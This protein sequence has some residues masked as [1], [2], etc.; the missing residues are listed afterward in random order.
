MVFDDIIIGSGLSALGTALGLEPGRRILVLA[1]PTHGAFSYY[2]ARR[3]VPCAYLGAGGLGNDWHGVIPMSLTANFGAATET[4][5]AALF[6]RFYPST[7]LA[8][9]LRQPHLF[10]PWRAIRPVPELARLARRS[11]G[12]LSTRPQ[13]AERF[14]WDDTGA[15]VSTRDGAQHR[16]H[17][18]WIAAGCLHTPRL[19]ERS[20]GK[21]LA[22]ECV[23]DHVVCYVGMQGVAPAP[24]IQRSRDGVFFPAHYA[25]TGGTLY[26]RRP[27]RFAFRKLDFGI[28]QRA[29]FG[30]PTGSA[31]A[32]IMRRMSAGL[33]A[34]A[35]YNRSGLF[36]AAKAYSVYAQTLVRDAYAF[37]PG[38]LPLEA[39]T[40]L[41]ARATAEA[42]EHAPFAD[43]QHSRR[44]ELYIPGI[45]LHH[46]LDADAVQARGLNLPGSPVQIVDASC[47]TDIG[48]DFHSFKLMLLACRRAREVSR[49]AS[50]ATNPRTGQ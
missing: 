32:K 35:L 9:Q 18:L 33:L 5:F 22:R 45:H 1:G 20:L 29:V 15:S 34:E 31:V 4:E 42:R 12:T 8:G 6:A 14:T 13:T 37:K 38:D 16:G 26:T 44:N 24:L 36:P 7:S 28:E 30:L 47:V 39:R 48:A 27:A 10:V 19:L 2:D 23:S 21:G 46:S 25:P 40:E 50:A 17:R 41:I 3:V 43:L 11:A 49:A